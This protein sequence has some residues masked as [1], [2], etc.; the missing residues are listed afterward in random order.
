MD[1]V[2]KALAHPVRREILAMLRSG[3]LPSGEIAA[4]FDLSWPTMSVHLAA[5]KEA[6]LVAAEREGT[7]IFYRLNASVAE[8]TAALILDLVGAGG[9]KKRKERRK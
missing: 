4:A 3:P 6:G 5:L 7:T 1:G 2:F 9:G 8:E